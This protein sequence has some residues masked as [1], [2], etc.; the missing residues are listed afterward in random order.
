MEQTLLSRYRLL[1]E[2]GKGGMAVVYR[3]QDTALDREVAVKVLH[4]FLADKDESR[5]RFQREAKVVAK[6]QHDNILEIFDYSGMDSKE[7]F[8]VTEFIHGETLSSFLEEYTMTVPEIG[9]LIV[10]EIAKAVNHAHESSIIHRDIKPENIMIRKD[11]VLKLMDFGIAQ[12]VDTQ[13]LTLTGQLLGSPAYM[14]PEMIIGGG[15][16]FRTDIFS[17]GVMLYR[18]AAGELPFVGKNPHEVLKK[19]AEADHVRPSMVNPAISQELEDIIEK[20]LELEKE[21]RYSDTREMINDLE[22]LLHSI[23]IEDP[24]TEARTFFLDPIS[25]D[26]ELRLLLVNRLLEEAKSHSKYGR[27]PAALRTLNRV[28]SLDE[29]NEKVPELLKGLKRRQNIRFFIKNMGLS[30][31]ALA[32]LVGVAYGIWQMGQPKKSLLPNLEAIISNEITLGSS[33]QADTEDEKALTAIT[34]TPWTTEGDTSEALQNPEKQ[35]VDSPRPGEHKAPPRND[36]SEK[37]SGLQR[38]TQRRIR[39]LPDK[40]NTEK[41]ITEKRVFKLI[42]FPP[43]VKVSVDG[44]EL[45]DYGPNLSTLTL[46]PGEHWIK[47]KSPYCYPKRIHIKPTD[48]ERVL[49]PKLRWRPAYL[50]VVS[51]VQADVLVGDK[52]YKST[53]SNNIPV[54]IPRNSNDGTVKVLV[55]VSATNYHTWQKKL[56]LKAGRTKKIQVELNEI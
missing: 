43:A 9:A 24:D 45:G 33:T 22:N 19:I 42:P 12:I 47:I 30:I 50:R 25:F 51:N 27:F 2:I 8:I 16:D 18:L 54:P 5:R 1:E 39:K 6:L 32:V 48:P 10:L 44:K 37:K 52:W 38:K 26:S 53:K 31:L 36:S 14:A 46:D 4:S 15:I 49:R 20:S 17:L 34:P 41:A 3:G 21:A 13:K 56:E 23:G 40:G 55:K 29:N 11:G 35:E 7:S 28:L